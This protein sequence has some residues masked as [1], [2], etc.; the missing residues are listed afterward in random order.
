MLKVICAE[1]WIRK[2]N[3]RR[4]HGEQQMR[5]SSSIEC[6]ETMKWLRMKRLLKRAHSEQE[7]GLRAIRDVSKQSE[8]TWNTNIVLNGATPNQSAQCKAAIDWDKV[9][10]RQIGKQWGRCY[11]N[12]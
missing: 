11:V 2:M 1:V 9:I 4:H 5:K 10:R 6:M 7:R 3:N 12:C 8:E